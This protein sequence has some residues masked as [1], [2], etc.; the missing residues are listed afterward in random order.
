[1]SNDQQSPAV[2][3]NTAVT[4]TV[5][6]KTDAES[7]RTSAQGGRK[8][9]QALNQVW[10]LFVSVLSW[11]GAE[12]KSAS[13]VKRNEIPPVALTC[14]RRGVWSDRPL[15]QTGSK[16]NGIKSWTSQR[17][18]LTVTFGIEG[19]TVLTCG[20]RR[21]RREGATSKT[22]CTVKSAKKCI[23]PS[24]WIVLFLSVFFFF[25][26]LLL[27]LFSFFDTGKW[28][29][30]LSTQFF[31]VTGWLFKIVKNVHNNVETHH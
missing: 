11:T 22:V 6:A 28:K 24:V 8:V 21:G 16:V 18:C 5:L 23:C 1:M 17:L 27:S 4:T 15:R 30:L 25:F 13:P 14:C 26:I 9:P 20:F 10:L 29:C 7:I 3:V 19:F 2:R 31:L 12:N